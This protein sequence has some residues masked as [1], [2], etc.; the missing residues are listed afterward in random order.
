MVWLSLRALAA[1]PGLWRRHEIGRSETLLFAPQD[2]AHWMS[3][4]PAALT[5]ADRILLLDAGQ[6]VAA[7]TLSELLASSPG[8]RALWHDE[9]RDGR[10]D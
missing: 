8:M 3:H 10:R 5:R 2:L 1:D 9:R 4:R 6:I 7:G